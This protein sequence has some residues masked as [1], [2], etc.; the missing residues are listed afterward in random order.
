[1]TA[2]DRIA[3]ARCRRGR[4]FRTGSRLLITRAP[5]CSVS[6]QSR[7]SSCTADQAA[8]I[9]RKPPAARLYGLPFGGYAQMMNSAVS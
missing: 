6:G 7:A 3:L 1:M 2:P 4:H 5:C 9:A 8:F